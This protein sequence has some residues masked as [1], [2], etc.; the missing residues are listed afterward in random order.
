MAKTKVMTLRIP[1]TWV[2][3]IDAAT[4]RKGHANRSAFLRSAIC[5][6]ADITPDL[7]PELLHPPAKD[8]PQPTG[9]RRREGLTRGAV[10]KKS[11]TASKE[12]GATKKKKVVR[13]TPKTTGRRRKSGLV[14]PD[15]QKR[16]DQAET[17]MEKPEPPPKP[18]LPPDGKKKGSRSPKTKSKKN[19]EKENYKDRV[20]ALA[21][22]EGWRDPVVEDE[23]TAELI[24][25]TRENVEAAKGLVEFKLGCYSETVVDA[26]NFFTKNLSKDA[27]GAR[28]SVLMGWHEFA[29]EHIATAV[30][31]WNEAGRP[32]DMGSD[33]I[34]L[35]ASALE[36]GGGHE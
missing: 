1:Y 35:R 32:T 17:R 19:E 36:S 11:K 9:K 4:K 21:A 20:K 6:E 18:Q 8:R 24:V 16:A 2:S 3:K 7:P 28:A 15:I 30:D 22:E 14:I 34:Y 26:F 23:K 5:K 33:E 25:R 29:D 10:A 31:Q 27:W 13:G 12:K